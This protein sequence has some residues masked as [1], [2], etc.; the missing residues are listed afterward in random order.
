MLAAKC[1]LSIRVDALGEHTDAHVGLEGR[2]KVT[3]HSRCCLERVLWEKTL[4][5]LKRLNRASLSVPVQCC[6]P[7]YTGIA[8]LSLQRASC[9]PMQGV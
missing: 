4:Q 6:T 2:E 9:I 7:C 5:S 3:H 8:P 1:S